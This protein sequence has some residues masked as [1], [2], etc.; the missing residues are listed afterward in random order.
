MAKVEGLEV[1]PQNVLIMPHAVAKARL[2][3]PSC[4]AQGDTYIKREITR[5]VCEAASCEVYDDK[6]KQFRGKG[7][8]RGTMLS[9]QRIIVHGDIAFIVDIAMLPR[10]TVVTVMSKLDRW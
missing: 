3:I 8:R 10:L 6:P 9:W 2:R 7:V 1:E 5:R 4:K